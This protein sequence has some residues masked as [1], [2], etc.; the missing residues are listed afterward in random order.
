MYAIQ[1]ST[2]YI[3]VRTARSLV[4]RL[5]GLARNVA[6]ISRLMEAGVD[7]DAVD[8]PTANKLTVH[9][10]VATAEHEREMISALTKAALAM[11]KARGVVLAP[12]PRL[13]GRVQDPSFR[14]VT[15]AGRSYITTVRNCVRRVMPVARPA[16]LKAHRVATGRPISP[17]IASLLSMR[18]RD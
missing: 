7:V 5:D 4:A 6:C 16:P 3:Q 2:S 8:M 17:A 14:I 9:I 1:P 15:V 18:P 12:L 10:L 11:V 13:F